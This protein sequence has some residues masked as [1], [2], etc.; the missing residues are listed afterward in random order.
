MD[1]F[2]W[3]NF[4]KDVLSSGRGHSRLAIHQTPSSDDGC[5]TLENILQTPMS[6]V[7]QRSPIALLPILFSALFLTKSPLQADPL[8]S[9]KAAFDAGDDTKTI[10]LAATIPSNPEAAEIA[11]YAHQRR[12]VTHF[13]AAEIDASITDFDAYLAHYPKRAPQHWQRGISYYYADRFEDGV[14]QFEIHQ[15]VNSQ[16]VE[17]AIFHFIC[18]ARAKSIGLE[19]ARKNFIPIT[20]DRRIPMAELHEL[21]RGDGTEAAVLAAAAAATGSSRTNALCYAHLY[22]GLYH[23]ALGNP[24]K[25]LTHIRKAAIDYAQP[26]YMGQVAKVHLKL[27]TKTK[28]NQ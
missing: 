3:F 10:E 6:P 11:A 9:L 1:I 16:D 5:E 23:E 24:E 26:H 13:Y 14:N 18:A 19:K 25:S 21:Y 20:S 28:S 2:R 12:G 7:F 15:T 22:L 27:R 8:D 4:A 17:N